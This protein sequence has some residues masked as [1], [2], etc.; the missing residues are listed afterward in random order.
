MSGLT[1]AGA[2]AV[3]AKWREKAIRW[4]LLPSRTWAQIRLPSAMSMVRN[5]QLPDAL[6]AIALRF[7]TEGIEIA[8]LTAE[9]LRDFEDFRV[10]MMLGAVVG[11]DAAGAD[12]DPDHP[13]EPKD[14]QPVAITLDVDDFYALPAADQAAIQQLVERSRTV[15]QVTAVTRRLRDLAEGKLVGPLDTPPAEEATVESLASFRPG[16]ASDDARPD[17]GAVQPATE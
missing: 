1:S 12:E 4:V 3:I 7:A 14:P 6:M 17:G 2:D 15:E 13:G 16:P 11:L 10:R 5:G 8:K 9:E